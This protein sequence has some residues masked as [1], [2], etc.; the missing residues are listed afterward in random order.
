LLTDRVV[1]LDNYAQLFAK[2]EQPAGAIKVF[3][4][5]SES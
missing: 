3:C 2:L 5:V 1:G 4:E